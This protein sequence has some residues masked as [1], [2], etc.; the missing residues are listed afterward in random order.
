MAIFPGTSRP[1][2]S[3]AHQD[4]PKLFQR[5][6]GRPQLHVIGP[7]HNARQK[8]PP[9]QNILERTS[10][11]S[12][13]KLVG[14]AVAA[15]LRQTARLGGAATTVRGL[16]QNPSRDCCTG[17]ARHLPPDPAHVP[18]L[19]RPAILLSRTLHALARPRAPA[20]LVTLIDL[21]AQPS[22]ATV[23][24]HTTLRRARDA[25][26]GRGER[27]SGPV[28]AVISRRIFSSPARASR[29]WPPWA[30]CA[31]RAGPAR[32]I[33]AGRVCAGAHAARTRLGWV[34]R[35]V[36]FE[37]PGARGRYLQ[38]PGQILG[39]RARAYRPRHW[40][41]HLSGN[42]A[43]HKRPLALSLPR[44][45]DASAPA[46]L[47]SGRDGTAAW[48]R[49]VSTHSRA[50]VLSSLHHTPISA[51]PR[52]APLS[53]TLYGPFMTHKCSAQP[54]APASRATRLSVVPDDALDARRCANADNSPGARRTCFCRRKWAGSGNGPSFG[55]NVPSTSFATIDTLAQG[56]DPL[57]F[58]LVISGA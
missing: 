6:S 52:P 27:A 46:L 57:D 2:Q 39:R 34:L 1:G 28:L 26:I 53:H 7:Q 30:I 22:M 45:G 8:G 17:P 43:A 12:T 9:C 44:S 54:A 41:A 14:A 21:R 37:P 20:V 23:L 11:I 24:L 38:F 33:C 49:T 10:K 48:S 31:R 29:P 56:Y 47:E 16:A 42:L 32:A 19:S 18:P 25:A 55:S 35:K 15:D 36:I 58:Y 5:N 50:A 13:D 51:R 4:D 3:S 40:G